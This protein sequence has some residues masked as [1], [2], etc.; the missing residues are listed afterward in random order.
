M[1]GPLFDA[2]HLRI[3][4]KVR[5]KASRRRWLNLAA[6]LLLLLIMALALVE[7]IIVLAQVL[8]HGG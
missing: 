4:A 6:I 5:A 1:S 3:A 7:I 2:R 8:L